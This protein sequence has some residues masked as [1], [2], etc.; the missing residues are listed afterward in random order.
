MEQKQEARGPSDGEMLRRV[1]GALTGRVAALLAEHGLTV[2]R[3]RVLCSLTETG[4]QTMSDLGRDTSITGPTLSRV[5]D[6]LVKDAL[7]YRN[8]DATDRRRVVVHA[9]DRGRAAV[10]RLRP[11]VEDAERRG[12]AALSSREAR[13]LRRFLERIDQ[14]DPRV[15]VKH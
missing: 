2:D 11:D 13:T 15:S 10:V 1:A 3:W 14:M 6:R 4:P 9:A 12:L 7:V 5:V 8:V